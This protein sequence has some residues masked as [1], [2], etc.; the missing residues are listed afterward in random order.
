VAGRT[1]FGMPGDLSDPDSYLSANPFSYLRTG[2]GEVRLS[3]A[4]GLGAEVRREVL[5]SATESTRR[6]IFGS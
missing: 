1:E 2:G 3:G 4:P 6:L 5:R